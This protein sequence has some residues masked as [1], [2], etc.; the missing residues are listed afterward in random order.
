MD[1]FTKMCI[2]TDINSAM[3]FLK[4]MHTAVMQGDTKAAEKFISQVNA[5]LEQVED[6]L[7]ASN[8]EL[9]FDEL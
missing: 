3:I 4:Q 5:C 2:T 9:V 8:N 6:E 7:V 1:K